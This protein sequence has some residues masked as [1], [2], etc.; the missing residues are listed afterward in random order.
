VRGRGRGIAGGGRA[1]GRLARPDGCIG[2]GRVGHGREE[3]LFRAAPLRICTLLRLNAASRVLF[4]LN[5]TVMCALPPRVMRK[6]GQQ[7]PSSYAPTAA[8]AG[9]STRVQIV[10]WL[11][12]DGET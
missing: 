10:A 9:Y 7:E 11:L 8:S 1:R 4:S 12:V 5:P 2:E 6:R 3:D